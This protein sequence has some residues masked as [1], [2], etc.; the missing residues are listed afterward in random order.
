MGRDQDHDVRRGVVDGLRLM[1]AG[2]L[3]NLSTNNVQNPFTPFGDAQLIRMANLFANVVQRGM[4]HDLR[5]VWDMFT[6][7]SAKLLRREGHGVAVGHAADLVVVDAPN[8]VQALRDISPVLY[9]FKAGRRTFTR[10]RAV[11]HRP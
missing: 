2:A 9:G 11:L 10:A 8:A 5:C 6:A 4:A 3:C 7:N 1:E